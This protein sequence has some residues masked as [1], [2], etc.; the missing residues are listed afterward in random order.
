MKHHFFLSAFVI[1]IVICGIA[2]AAGFPVAPFFL[3]TV[4]AEILFG[5]HLNNDRPMRVLKALAH[6]AKSDHAARMRSAH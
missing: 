4:V 3:I 2:L 5:L 1:L 6:E